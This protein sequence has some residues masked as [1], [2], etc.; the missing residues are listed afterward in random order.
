[1]RSHQFAILTYIYSYKKTPLKTLKNSRKCSF[2]SHSLM[3]KMTKN[4]QLVCNHTRLWIKQGRVSKLKN[5]TS[6]KIQKIY[7]TFIYICYL[8]FSCSID[9]LI[10][11]I[12]QHQQFQF[13]PYYLYIYLLYSATFCVHFIGS[14]LF[15]CTQNKK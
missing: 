4:F 15:V 8:E 1:M 6:R 12:K 10:C 11:K 3:Q 14:A 7:I 5:S 2:T 13:L 9:F